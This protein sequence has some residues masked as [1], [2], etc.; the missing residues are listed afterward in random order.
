[1]LIPT[2]DDVLAAHARIA[3]YIHRT[4]I[5]TSSYLDALTGASLFFKCE[6]FQKAGAFKVRGASNAVFGL[7]DAVV[8]QDLD[9]FFLGNGTTGKRAI[10]FRHKFQPT[11]AQ[12]RDGGGLLAREFEF[13]LNLRRNQH[14]VA[15]NLVLYFAEACELRR[16]E[17]RERLSV[18][19]IDQRK[20]TLIGSGRGCNR[21]R[22]RQDC[23]RAR[24]QLA[25]QTFDLSDLGSAEAKV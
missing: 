1:M 10:C 12:G 20:E 16:S 9:T 7:S 22:L 3:P 19:I 14:A 6:N 25:L 8:T 13:F 11:N 5:L 24:L 18:I 17:K 21:L 15:Q 23:F 2:Y 4:P